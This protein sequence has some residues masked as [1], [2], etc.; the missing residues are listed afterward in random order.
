MRPIRWLACLVGLLLA[1]CVGPRTDLVRSGVVVLNTQSP[2]S[3]RL[4]GV[5]VYEGREGA[6]VLG[7][8]ER[9]PCTSGIL[10]GH[11][12]VVVVGADGQVLSST[13]VRLSPGDVPTHE[14]RLSHFQARIAVPPPGATVRVS[15]RSGSAGE[16]VLALKGGE[17]R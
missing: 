8:V 13:P 7:S 5:G 17:S 6:V 10:R 12:D 15:Y 1:G 16:T 3:V 4:A 9:L 14:P 11:V 2:G